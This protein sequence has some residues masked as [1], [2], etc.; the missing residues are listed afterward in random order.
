MSG[1]IQVVEIL[2]LEI[3]QNSWKLALFWDFSTFKAISW[4]DIMIY[5][6][7]VF[8]WSI[9]RTKIYMCANFQNVF[10][11]WYGVTTGQKLKKY[12]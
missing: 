7:N 2:R 9:E 8:I 11:L 5:D 1:K 12:H 4:P 6:G 10:D 3:C